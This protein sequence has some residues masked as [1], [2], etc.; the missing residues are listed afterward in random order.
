MT[1]TA[2]AEEP[3]KV[4]QDALPQVTVQLTP[5]FLGSLVTVA[6]MPHCSLTIMEVGGRKPGVNVTVIGICEEF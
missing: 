2:L 6:A 5:A 4:P 3:L 1:G